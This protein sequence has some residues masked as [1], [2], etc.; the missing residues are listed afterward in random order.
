MLL[1]ISSFAV[2]LVL[3]TKITGE[4]ANDYELGN[5]SSHGFVDL[6]LNYNALL[7]RSFIPSMRSSAVFLSCYTLLIALLFFFALKIKRDGDRIFTFSLL[8][9]FLIS[10]I[11]YIFLGI[12]THTRE[13]ERFLYL[14]SALQCILA[15]YAI[16][17]T[18]HSIRI[19]LPVCLLL[20]GYNALLL[21]TNRK[22]YGIASKIS[23]NIYHKVDSISTTSKK[24]VI[25][26]LPS[27][28]NGV[29]LFREGFKEGLKWLFNADT[30]K[31]L[32]LN[33]PMLVSRPPCWYFSKPDFTMTMEVRTE[34]GDNTL[35]KLQADTNYVTFL[36]DSLAIS[37]YY[38]TINL[39]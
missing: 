8:F 3:R 18:I 37:N 38:R 5:K 26:N 20:F 24:V 21:Y 6:F 1:Y 28:F 15:G 13:S 12:D 22:D 30:S 32:I 29:P 39:R 31:I 35:L 14:P 11:P 16:V 34:P 36:P 25:Y 4:L 10:F 2:H 17:K 33:T 9:L 27:Q 19:L 7:A 23:T